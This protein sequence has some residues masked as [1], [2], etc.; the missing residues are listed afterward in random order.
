M[1]SNEL[2]AHDSFVVLG[3]DLLK[4]LNVIVLIRFHKLGH[5]DDFRLITERFGL[6]AVERIDLRLHKHENNNISPDYTE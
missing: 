6:L 1:L 3:N 5:N 4:Q 2:V